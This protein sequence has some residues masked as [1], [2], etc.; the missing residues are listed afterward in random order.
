[1]ARQVHTRIQSTRGVYRPTVSNT[2][3]RPANT[4]AYAAGDLVANDT[5]AA[6]VTP[7]V[8]STASL[9]SQGA[10]CIRG[11][12]IVKNNTVNA[13][14]TFKVHF[15]SGS[16]TVTNG[17]NAA[18]SVVGTTNKWLGAITV[19]MSDSTAVHASLGVHD[20]YATVPIVGELDGL[21]LYAL[22]EARAAYTPASGET[23][24]LEALIEQA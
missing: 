7:F 18:F 22:I 1:M 10:I 9:F 2:I 13:N 12:K 15:F 6:S 19:T 17:D 11:V 3:T 4:T 8:F 5:V 24:T 23:F 20:G 14:A 21:D 16:I